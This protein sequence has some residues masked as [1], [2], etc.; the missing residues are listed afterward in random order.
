MSCTITN[1][2]PLGI[3]NQLREV[4]GSN[5]TIFQAHVNEFNTKEFKTYLKEKGRYV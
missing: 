4:F 1:D 5:D 3:A 2:I